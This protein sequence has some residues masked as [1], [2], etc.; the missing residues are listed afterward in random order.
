MLGHMM[1]R[2]LS[3]DPRLTVF[4]S[5]RDENARR[6][7]APE[8]R[9]R[10]VPGVN[11]ESHDS[12]VGLMASTRPDVVVNCIGLVKQLA[13][14]DD[15]LAAIPMNS[16][17]PHRLAALCR[18]RSARLIHFS[19]D[20][21]FSGERGNYL[22]TDFPDARDLYGR[23]KLLGE[24]AYEHTVTLRTSIIGHELSGAH[25][26]LAQQGRV[27]GFTRAVFSG[28]PT[29]ELSRVVQTIVLHR[30]DLNGVYHVAAAPVDKYSLLNLIARIY[31]KDV[32]VQPDDKLVID[33]S[34]SADKFN[35]LTGYCPPS[36][37]ELVAQMRQSHECV[38]QPGTVMSP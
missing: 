31:E 16:L 21:V 35:G 34:L 25:G 22:E 27:R 13:A 33:R 11:V 24:L 32:T 7:F 36:W 1:F 26:L 17:L 12:V 20:C 30:P 15:P 19:T 29:D 8:H 5:I 38:F 18:I 37:P 9:A 28:L 2:T 6:W 3:A 23:S 10:L 14:A 4:G